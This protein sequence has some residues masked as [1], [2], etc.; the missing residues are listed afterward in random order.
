[1]GKR[2]DIIKP[3]GIYHEKD[4]FGAGRISQ[5]YFV[6]LRADSCVYVSTSTYIT[7][8]FNVLNPS[9]PLNCGKVE[10]IDALE[11][12]RQQRVSLLYLIH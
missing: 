3:L 6:N 8:T 1:M 11:S 9:N 2:I 10:A 7:F 4:I 5:W 12:K